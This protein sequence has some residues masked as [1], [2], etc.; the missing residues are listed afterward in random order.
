L[1][2]KTH[3]RPSRYHCPGPNGEHPLP[4]LKPGTPCPRKWS[5]AQA[6][7]ALKHSI[8]AGWLSDKWNEDFPRFVWYRDGDM[9]LDLKSV[10]RTDITLILL[11]Y[12]RFLRH[13][14][15][16]RVRHKCSLACACEH[17]LK[18]AD[19]TFCHLRIS[20]GG[21]NVTAY[22]TEDRHQEDHIEIPSYYLAEWIAENWWPLLWEPRKNEDRQSDDPD[23]LSRHS[24]L[25]AQH[26]F[27]LPNVSL[28]PTGENISIYAAGRTAKYA[29]AQF[30]ARAESLVD[31][32]GVEGELRK[33]IEGTIANLNGVPIRRFRAHGH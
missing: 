15:G 4:R 32:S 24:I 28:V 17:A 3:R 6:T 23:F 9:R 8:N 10:P 12:L 1:F 19:A 25:M 11:K 13:S 30:T 18:G 33:F 5:I 21:E 22:I 2:S 27:V 14:I 16:K 26:G 20:V 31:R 7:I 29:D